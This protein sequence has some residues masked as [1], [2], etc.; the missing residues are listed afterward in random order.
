MRLPTTRWHAAGTLLRVLPEVRGKDRIVS[1]MRGSKTPPSLAASPITV[2]FGP[3]LVATVD[4]GRD[5]S[6][7]D[8]FFIQF[9][10]PALVPVLE[11]V[12]MPGAVF[13]DIGANVGVYSLW[14]A[15]LVGDNGRVY[16][17]E[18]VPDDEGGDDNFRRAEAV[19]RRVGSLARLSSHPDRLGEG[20]RM[21]GV[22]QLVSPEQR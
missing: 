16:A 20:I 8:M 13:L 3:G 5:G 2:R 14:A 12:L 15:R 21:R 1:L 17:F 6:F 4:V 18:P 7:A 10:K 9:R 19:N 22:K 11:A